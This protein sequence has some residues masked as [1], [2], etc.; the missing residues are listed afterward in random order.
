M[1]SRECKCKN[2]ELEIPRAYFII[3]PDTFHWR[4]H[5]NCMQHLQQVHINVLTNQIL[6][7]QAISYFAKKLLEVFKCIVK[8]PMFLISQ[9]SVI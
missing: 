7:L 3:K 9:F 8:N 6:K 2:Q 5:Q 1:G 4:L